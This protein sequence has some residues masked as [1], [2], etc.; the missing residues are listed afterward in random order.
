M[1]TPNRLSYF[2][3]ILFLLVNTLLSA[4]DKDKYTVSILNDITNERA[5]ELIEALKREI[6]NV[7]G[8]DK[9]IS[10][11]DVV[12]NNLNADKAKSDYLNA[13][14]NSDIILAF[15]ALNTKVIY[16]RNT[17][18]KPTIV[19]SGVNK[20]FMTLS[21]SQKTSGEE[22]ITFL[23]PPQSYSEDLDVFINI[24]P[25]NAFWIVTLMTNLK[26]TNL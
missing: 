8:Q 13:A 23:I 15:G 26:N 1:N 9:E 5:V 16:E 4:Q 18:P 10:F 20:D 11:L 14:S 22:N 12:E 2:F 3:L 17:Y 7:V 21:K 19:F 24:Y 25:L 6:K